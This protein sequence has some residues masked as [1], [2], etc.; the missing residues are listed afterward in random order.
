MQEY[1]YSVRMRALVAKLVGA[2]LAAEHSPAPSADDTMA[3][4]TNQVLLMPSG[5]FVLM[6]RR[7]YTAVLQAHD[8]PAIGCLEIIRASANEFDRARM[9]VDEVRMEDAN[10]IAGPVMR[11]MFSSFDHYSSTGRDGIRLA[12]LHRMESPYADPEGNPFVIR[13]RFQ[14]YVKALTEYKRQAF[15]A[16]A[17]AA[18]RLGV[19]IDNLMEAF[20][21]M[22]C[23]SANGH[24][25]VAEA[26]RK[27][28]H[29]Q[30]T[31]L[32]DVSGNPSQHRDT[33]MELCTEGK[34][35]LAHEIE[36]YHQLTGRAL[37][38]GSA[39]EE[40]PFFQAC[41]NPEDQGFRLM[42]HP[43]MM[44]CFEATRLLSEAA[45]GGGLAGTV[46]VHP[47]YNYV[48]TSGNVICFTPLADYDRKTGEFSALDPLWSSLVS[49]GM[50]TSVR[51]SGKIAEADPDLNLLLEAASHAASMDVTLTHD[52]ALDE[53]IRMSYRKN[54]H[55]E[56]DAEEG[57]FPCL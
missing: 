19:P 40:T 7:L 32:L 26:A 3:G 17:E 44:G 20:G 42:P 46:Q 41:N 33:Y 22:C 55:S 48:V 15:M 30:Y 5:R 49:C 37:Q 50:L 31:T 34:F 53:K 36:P 13:P 6:H 25:P 35:K 14:Q 38:S 23:Y 39:I 2:K 8:D 45:T 11:A 54:R 24:Y 52:A 10:D 29:E 21:S 43:M 1:K 4:L 28:C 47:A 27:V 51:F 9:L 57:C 56:A 16:R 18:K 12:S